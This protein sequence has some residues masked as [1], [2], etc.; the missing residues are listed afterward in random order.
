M[1]KNSIYLGSVY[2]YL[3]TNIENR[4][5]MLSSYYLGSDALGV[6]NTALSLYESDYLGFL[7]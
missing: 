6:V 2:D 5:D 3:I 7:S 4:S 1:K